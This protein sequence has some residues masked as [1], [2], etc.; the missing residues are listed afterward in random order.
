MW[1]YDVN[2]QFYFEFE[3]DA[4]NVWW[5]KNIVEFRV[6]SSNYP[7]WETNAVAFI[8]IYAK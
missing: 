4:F 2:K 5:G 8:K 6:H 1:I 3:K 7:Y